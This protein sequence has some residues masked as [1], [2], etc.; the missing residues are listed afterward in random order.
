MTD[1]L[2]VMKHNRELSRFNNAPVR[3]ALHSIDMCIYS[4][5]RVFVVIR[6]QK[7]GAMRP[8]H[9]YKKHC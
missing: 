5:A 6:H 8:L 7:M 2:P 4:V 9:G 1:S 3:T